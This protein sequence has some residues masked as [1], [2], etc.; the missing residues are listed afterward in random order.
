MMIEWRCPRCE[1]ITKTGPTIRHSYCVHCG[2]WKEEIVKDVVFI[3]PGA[4]AP[5]SDKIIVEEML[6]VECIFNEP[7]EFN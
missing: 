4:I 2:C 5:V 3:G 6:D 1:A 7:D